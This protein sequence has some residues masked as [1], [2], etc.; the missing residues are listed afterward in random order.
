MGADL[1][2]PE[3]SPEAALAADLQAFCRGVD[4]SGA[5]EKR[6]FPRIIVIVSHHYLIS[7]VIIME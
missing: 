3:K 1:D 2:S 4:E 5:A 6:F 7:S